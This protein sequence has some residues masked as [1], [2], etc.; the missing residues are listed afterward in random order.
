MEYS[1]AKANYTLL[2]HLAKSRNEQIFAWQGLM[3]SNYQTMNYDSVDIFAQLI[4]ERGEAS[5][6]AENKALLFL[7]KSA[8]KK[9]QFDKAF[10]FFEKTM[11]AGDDEHAAEAMFRIAEMQ[12]ELAE[13]KTSTETCID[14]IARF[15]QFGNWNDAAFLRIAE[16]FYQMEEYFQARST[17]ESIIANSPSAETVKKAKQLL[18]E[19]EQKEIKIIDND[20]IE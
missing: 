3:L 7:G 13:F 8:R 17:L 19:V 6:G 20:T 15:G 14:L 5:F 2:R 1:Q 16:N 18:K 12:S 4:I 9:G 11:A 10:E